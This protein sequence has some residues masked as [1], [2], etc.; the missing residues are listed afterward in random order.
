M[1]PF[2][3]T[4]LFILALV[5]PAAM[6]A[7]AES[8]ITVLFDAGSGSWSTDYSQR[9]ASVNGTLYIARA[10]GLYSYRTGDEAPKQ[11]MDFAKTDLAGSPLPETKYAAMFIAELLSEN[12]ALYALDTK[13]S[14]LWRFD[15]SAAAFVKEVSFDASEGIGGGAPGR[16]FCSG[17]FLEGGHVYYTATNALADT[18][19]LMRQNAKSGKAELVKNSILMAVPYAPGVLLAGTGTIGR[20]ES[21]ALLDTATGRL[22]KKLSLTGDYTGLACD[23]ATDTVYLTRKGGIYASK[24]FAEPKVV[25]RI[26]IA[27][28]VSEGALLPGGHLALPYEDGVRIYATGSAALAGTPLRF[29]G[30]TWELPMEAF[31]SLN[32]GVTFAFLDAYPRNT[33][34]LVTHMMG[35]SAAADI[36]VLKCRSYSLDDLYQKGYFAGLEDSSLVKDTVSALYPFLKNALLRD[37]HVIALPFY[38]SYAL[39]GYN[40][41]AFEEVGLTEAD[42]PMTYDGLLDFIALWGEEYA[43]LYPSMSLFGAGAAPRL[44]KRIIANEI[45]E[46]R[47]YGCRRRGEPITFDTPEMRALLEKLMATDFSA[48]GGL[49]PA[50]LN[51]NDPI[52]AGWWPQ[53]LFLLSFSLS[54]QTGYSTYFTAMPLKLTADAQP[55]VLCDV[56]ILIVNPYTQNFDTALNFVEFVAG[57][58]PK[59]LRTDLMPGENEPLRDPAFDVSWLIES[60]EITEKALAE[61]KEEDKRMLRDKLERLRWEYESQMAYEWLTTR[62]SIAAFRALDPYFTLQLPNPIYG[63]GANEELWALFNNRFL[64]GQISAAQFLMELDQKIRMMHLEE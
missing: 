16:F 28:P 22:T 4:L 56:Q 12:G 46:A 17:F 52:P 13:L 49:A 31:S 58:L 44:H 42:I 32:P 63:M 29:A 40:P 43:E 14:A 3:K 15:E 10:D 50:I 21:L 2:A 51:E 5:L 6:P 45:L 18:V 26:P 36:Y 61:A 62:E 25:A 54:A 38:S 47:M 19:S 11:L 55:L 8:V 39:Y 59:P 20:F 7:R 23:P 24:S 57:R 1:K 27:S 37:G 60:M 30:H 53:D 41:R 64:D 35:G 48:I 33:M 9:V 34:E